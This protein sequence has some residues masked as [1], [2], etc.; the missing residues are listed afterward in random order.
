MNKKQ[1]I[2]PRMAVIKILPANI[3]SGST[4]TIQ[5]AE[6]NETPDTDGDGFFRP[7]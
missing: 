2:H 4:R 6:D 5:H 3:L 1:Y 7:E